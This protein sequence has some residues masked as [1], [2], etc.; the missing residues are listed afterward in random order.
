MTNKKILIT[1]GS[2]FIAKN[3]FENL[4]DKYE[5]M[6]PA[7]EELDLLDSVKVFSYIKENNFDIIINAANYDAAP[8]FTKKDPSK[9]LE[10]NLNMFFNIARCEGYFEKMIFFGSGAEFDRDN[11]KPKMSED[12]FDQH[13]PKD[14]YGLSKYIMT[15]YAQLSDNIY[16]LRLFAVFGKYNDWRYRFIS[17]ISSKAVLGLPIHVK[18]N[19]VYDFLYVDDLAK[20]VEWFIENKPKKNVYNVCHG[21]PFAWKEIA[22]KVVKISSKDLKIIIGSEGKEYS[23]D[24]SLLLSEMKD[25][26]FTP[27]DTSLKY[28]YEWY[29]QNK[30]FLKEEFFLGK[31]FEY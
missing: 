3:L 28:M 30:H 23:G 19:S 10:M 21:R 31:K 20:I 9:V 22:E 12:Y 7:R 15:K 1:G 26:K 25:L 5:I 2:G 29:E 11:W 27:I 8:N 16:N 17:N 13:V 6:T 24:S 14:Q 18:Q 4:K